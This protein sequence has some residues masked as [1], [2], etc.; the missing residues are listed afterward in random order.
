L[1]NSVYFQWLA[2]STELFIEGLRKR[3][4][5]LPEEKRKGELAELTTARNLLPL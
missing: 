3:D 4:S 1:F 5:L 2:E